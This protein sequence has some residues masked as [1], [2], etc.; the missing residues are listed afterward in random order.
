MTVISCNRWNCSLWDFWR[1]CRSSL[2]RRLVIAYTCR[3]LNWITH[4][5]LSLLHSHPC[6][7]LLSY[8]FS[9]IIRFFFHFFKNFFSIKS[10]SMNDANVSLAVLSPRVEDASQMADTN[11]A[12]GTGVAG[13][14]ID[15]GVPS[16][17]VWITRRAMQIRWTLCDS[18]RWFWT[19]PTRLCSIVGT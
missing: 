5:F 8:H 6:L 4:H 15:R 18:V 1:R 3:C 2:C 19:V 14:F 13:I 10:H 11:A 7:Q 17:P 9:V 16:W 12:S